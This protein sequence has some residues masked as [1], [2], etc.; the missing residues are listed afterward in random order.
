MSYPD[1]GCSYPSFVPYS[2]RRL[3]KYNVLSCCFC[4][5]V[6]QSYIFQFS[7]QKDKLT[8]S[9]NCIT[10]R[11]PSHRNIPMR[12]VFYEWQCVAAQ[13]TEVMSMAWAMVSRTSVNRS[14]ASTHEWIECFLLNLNKKSTWTIRFRFLPMVD[15]SLVHLYASASAKTW[16]VETSQTRKK[17][18]NS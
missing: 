11:K 6:D 1:Q 3:S 12:S 18:G 8:E 17:A 7:R 2:F 10:D 16:G 4:P 5:L 9:I 14:N 13:N 15:G